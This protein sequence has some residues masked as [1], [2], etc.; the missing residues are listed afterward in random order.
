M[1]KRTCMAR[2]LAGL[3]FLLLSGGVNPVLAQDAGLQERA[4][5]A[6]VELSVMLG[7]SVDAALKAR[8]ARAPAPPA[9]IVK[10]T[11]TKALKPVQVVVH[12]DRP[13]WV[14]RPPHAEDMLYGV[15]VGRT[16]A[17]AFTEASTL[18]AAQI[19]VKIRGNTVISETTRGAT[20]SVDGRVI[21]DIS[22]GTDFASSTSQLMVNAAIDDLSFEDQYTESEEKIHV[23]VSLDLAAL[24]E[25]KQAIVDSVLTS[26]AR[27][28]EALLRGIRED[29]VLDQALLVGMLMAL[30]EANDM[31]RSRLGKGVKKQWKAQYKALKRVVKKWVACVV[32]EKSGESRLEARCKELPLVNADFRV[33]VVGGVVAGA[34]EQ[35]R[36]DDQGIARFQQGRVYGSKPVKVGLTHFFSPEDGGRLLGRLRPSS[37]AV[38]KLPADEAATVFV[39]VTGTRGDE[40]K[41]VQNSVSRW[42]RSK[43]GTTDVSRASEAVMKARVTVEFGAAAKASGHHTQNVNVNVILEQG[44]Q[45][46]LERTFN[47]G[48][49]S[50]SARMVREEALKNVLMKLR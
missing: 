25:K 16:P 22:S 47:A 1:R 46:L 10:P 39:A 30:D 21:K 38:F 2:M 8:C 14:D 11:R 33:H 17:A 3:S 4:D 6:Q 36:T 24:R 45:N 41:Q 50:K 40:K 44:S 29:G 12:S 20:E 34:P 15:G 19:R 9:A 32:I 26:M 43:W 37:G 28:G 42:L 48:A 27:S 31:G 35:V 23:L 18:V 49:L 7:E 13:E 5:C